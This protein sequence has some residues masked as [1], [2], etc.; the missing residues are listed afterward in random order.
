MAK[1][2]ILFVT[3]EVIPFSKTGGLA[4]VAGSLARALQELG[5]KVTIITPFYRITKQT[6][7]CE[8]SGLRVKVPLKERLI[9]GNFMKSL[10]NGGIEVYLLKRDEFYDRGSLYSTAEGD[11]F[12]NAERFIF[13]CRAVLEFI[14]KK[15]LNIDIIHCHDWHTSLIPVYCKTLYKDY[16]PHNIT[17]VFTIHNIAYQGVFPDYSFPYTGL[18]QSLFNVDCLEFWGKVNFMKAG[19][20]FSDIITTVSKKYSEEIQTPEYSYGLE[21]VLKCR[22]KDLY[23]I[24]NGVDYKE[25]NPST[26]SLI[27]ANYSEEE[28]SGKRLCKKDL[29]KE[30]K[31]NIAVKKPLIG[32]ISRLSSQKGL[33]IFSQAI[34]KLMGFDLG[35][36]ILGEGDRSYQ[37]LL[38][39]LSKRY[40]ERLGVRIKFDNTLAHK[41]EAGADILLMPSRYEPCSLNQMYSLKYGTI[42][43]VR[44]TG[45]LD[46]T[47]QDYNPK[48][49]T[50]NGFKFKDYSHN[51][52]IDKVRFALEFYKDKKTWERLV[53]RAMRED[54][55]WNKSAMEYEKVYQKTSGIKMA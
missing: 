12:D 31:L 46:D 32:I 2:N 24:L 35:V 6:A 43:I 16:L 29:L 4:D 38:I 28:I 53:K 17:T 11:Y 42:P 48:T 26:D 7:D 19:I 27:A 33:D 47:I 34:D 45:G 23:G 25:W 22:S 13:F 36:V 37:E 8:D 40:P 20:L 1:Y 14:K 54:F 3:S 18:P 15:N 21:G 52:L 44:A 10:L 41:I 50:G 9:E 5:N 55:S 49:G 39:K 51:A 30:F